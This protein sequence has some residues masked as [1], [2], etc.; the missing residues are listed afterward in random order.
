M[1][2]QQRKGPFN[3]DLRKPQR[4]GYM[5][6]QGRLHRVFKRRFFVLYPGFL[7]YYEDDI[8][9]KS[10]LAKGDTLGVSAFASCAVCMHVMSLRRFAGQNWGFV[11][12][13]LH[14]QDCEERSEGL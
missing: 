5:L 4:T 8:K 9:W 10:D 13:E 2:S 3:F 12:E 14:L 6:K 7:V 11:P 1:T